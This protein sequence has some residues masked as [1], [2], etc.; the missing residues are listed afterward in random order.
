MDNV[1]LCHS[2]QAKRDTESRNS[3]KVISGICRHYI[4]IL[5]FSLLLMTVVTPA[6]AAELSLKDFLPS[7]SFAEEWAIEGE[8]NVF[9][10]DNLFDHIDG[11][12][13]LYFPYGFDGLA[14]AKYI[15]EENRDLSIV[16]DVYK[17]GSLLDAFGIYSN[18]RKASNLWVAV[19][20][21]GFVSP[22]QL[23]FYQ[24]R[25]FVRLQVSGVTNLP[26][27]ILLACAR[28]ISGKLP[29]GAGQ[30]K[31]LEILK[32]EALVPK[33]ERYLVQSMLGYVFFRQ[34]LIADA[35][36]QNERMQIFAIHKDTPA[37]ARETFDQYAAY[38]KAEGHGVQLTDNAEQRLLAADDPLY[39]GVRVVQAGR[40]V[41]GT[42]RVKNNQLAGQIIEQL[43]K[44][45]SRE[46]GN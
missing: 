22:T 1:S 23:M 24:D 3:F 26:Q 5:V 17:M 27:D 15:N 46:A 21:E 7:Q 44:R 6:V 30:P 34:G 45:I 19:G 39:G 2:V 25:Y 33:S 8:V 40:Y 20:A 43:Q 13:E 10:K 16:A 35:V 37:A 29:A 32:I 42:V 9:D 14:T 4:R 11:E 28:V 12:A 41:A 38:L 31:E 18:Y 36:L